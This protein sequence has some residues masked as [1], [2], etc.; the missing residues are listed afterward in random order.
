MVWSPTLVLPVLFSEGLAVVIVAVVITVGVVVL[1]CF[2]VV[3]G[4]VRWL[5]GAVFT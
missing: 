2:A 4:V 1:V 3:A 5:F